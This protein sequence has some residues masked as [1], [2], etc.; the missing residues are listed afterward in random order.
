MVSQ[1]G[2]L[3]K[4][5]KANPADPDGGI[6]ET[7]SVRSGNVDGVSEV[8]DEMATRQQRQEAKQ[9]IKEFVKDMVKGRKMTVMTQSVQLKT[10]S[11]YLNRGLDTFSIKVSGQ[12]RKI[13]LK[14]IEEI[15]C[16]SEPIEGVDTP[17]DELCATLMLVSDDCIT[18][19]L[20]DLNA[21]DTFV[22]CLM[23]F[24]NKQKGEVCMVC[25]VCKG[26]MVCMVCGYKPRS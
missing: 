19:R 4:F 18:F 12:K 9:V 23:M 17:L 26:C 22:M 15:H 24:C 14:D 13:L 25:M 16:G 5:S 6:S 2:E 8:V 1:V 20:N 10:C 11:A 21:R 3:P 7:S